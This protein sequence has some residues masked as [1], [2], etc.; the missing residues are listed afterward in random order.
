MYTFPR[1]TVLFRE[2]LSRG[3]GEV[4]RALVWS[5][6]F[7]LDPS[8]HLGKVHPLTSSI[9]KWLL[10]ALTNA[11][12]QGAFLLIFT[13]LLLDTFRDPGSKTFIKIMR[14]K[15]TVSVIS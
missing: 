4:L 1:S 14:Y 2:V 13:S 7:S 9:S 12:L 6:V 11:G 5:K 15:L 8:L 10:L 3:V